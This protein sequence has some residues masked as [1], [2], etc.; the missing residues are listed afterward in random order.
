MPEYYHA[1]VGSSRYT[2]ERPREGIFVLRGQSSLTAQQWR[3]ALDRVAA[4]NPGTHLR[5]IGRRRRSCWQS[6]GRPPRLRMLERCD[7]D[8]R[9]ERGADFIWATPLPL[10]TG[11]TIELIVAPQG[12]ETSLI[13]LRALHAVADGSG[14]I[15]FL[16]ELFRALRG[17]PLLGSNAGF[18]DV[19]L[20]LSVDATNSMSRHIKTTWLTGKPAGDEIG[21]E[22]RR[23]DLG[24]PKKN[25]LPR[26]AAAMAEFAHQYSDLPALIAIPVDLRRHLPGLR[27]TMNFANML[28]VP[29]EK[30]EGVDAFRSRLQEML[31]QRMEMA[32]PRALE[33]L[34]IVPLPWLDLLLSR[35]RLNYRNRKPLETAV[36]SNVGRHDSAALSGPGFKLQ[37]MIVLPLPGSAFATLTGLDDRVEMMMN[38]PKVLAGN[39]R[40]DALVAHL[41]SRLAEM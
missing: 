22:F 15:H 5:M 11:P 24:S 29:L 28:L 36:I 4:A 34:K 39:G 37:D 23:I 40:F 31:A 19:D 21:D 16:Y 3:Q 33:H 26:A 17:E 10:R 6:D 12:G 8:A 35:T 38:L 14:M 18:S 2:L 25:L 13:I 7:W 30:G 27:S 32:Y 9:S 41:Q 1:S 20:M